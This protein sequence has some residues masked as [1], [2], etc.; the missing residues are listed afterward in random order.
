MDPYHEHVQQRQVCCDGKFLT[1]YKTCELQP[2]QGRVASSFI[3]ACWRTL[4]HLWKIQHHR[5]DPGRTA[6]GAMLWIGAE[7]L[8]SQ[9]LLTRN[10][11]QRQWWQL[12]LLQS[13]LFFFFTD[14]FLGA[15]GEHLIFYANLTN[16]SLQYWCKIF[17]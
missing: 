16:I 8:G 3:D 2:S 5:R 15:F 7:M 14:T 12:L 11:F 1:A 4:S 17:P 9:S 6:E 13:L 10:L